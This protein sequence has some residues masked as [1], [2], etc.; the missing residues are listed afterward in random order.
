LGTEYRKTPLPADKEAVSGG[1]NQQNV[2]MGVG[3]E[4]HACL[5]LVRSRILTLANK[6][7]P[8]KLVYCRTWRS[9]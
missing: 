3:V 8:A 4:V 9:G 6:Q 1:V 2:G 5:N 7:G